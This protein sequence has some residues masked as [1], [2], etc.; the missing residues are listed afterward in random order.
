MCLV[1][2]HGVCAVPV[3]VPATPSVLVAPRH[4]AQPVTTAAAA[5]AAAPTP[6]RGSLSQ[7]SQAALAVAV[8]EG[9]LRLVSQPMYEVRSRRS[10]SVATITQNPDDTISGA[11]NQTLLGQLSSIPEYTALASRAITRDHAGSGTR[12]WLP[13]PMFLLQSSQAHRSARHAAPVPHRWVFLSA[14]SISCSTVRTRS[15][16]RACRVAC[17][18]GNRYTSV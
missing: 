1:F 10:A 2:V 13:Q 3:A 16:M 5:A 9:R 18:D 11:V 12:L 14:S 7:P 6:A 17:R 15:R 8:M 4:G